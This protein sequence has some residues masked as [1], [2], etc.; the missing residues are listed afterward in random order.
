MLPHLIAHTS[1]L[2]TVEELEPGCG[3]FPNRRSG[4]SQSWTR[5]SMSSVS[6]TWP[7]EI[8]QILREEQEQHYQAMIRERDEPRVTGK[9]D[10][11]PISD[12]ETT[13]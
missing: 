5:L 2:G 10:G 11:P 7:S 8:R 12:Q 13:R 3:F 6:C 1:K 4:W 9:K